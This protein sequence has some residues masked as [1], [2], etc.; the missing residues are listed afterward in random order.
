MNFGAIDVPSDTTV[1]VPGP[2]ALHAVPVAAADAPDAPRA[3][4]NATASPATKAASRPET[5]ERDLTDKAP[6]LTPEIQP[7]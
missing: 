4:L 6:T 2:E 7:A 5:V 3:V 1:V